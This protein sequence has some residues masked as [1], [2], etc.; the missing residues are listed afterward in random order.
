MRSENGEGLDNEQSDPAKGFTTPKTDQEDNQ[1]QGLLSFETVNPAGILKLP[2]KAVRKGSDFLFSSSTDQPAECSASED[3]NA[4]EPALSDKYLKTDPAFNPNDV[5]HGRLPEVP[6]VTPG[7][8]G[9]SNRIGN[10]AKRKVTAI[11]HPK[12]AAKQRFQSKTAAKLSKATR[13]YI[14]KESDREYLEA[15][16]ELFKAE[17]E[18]RHHKEEEKIRRRSEGS[19]ISVNQDERQRP[20]IDTTET[21]SVQGID[22]CGTQ[23]H[24]I[25]KLEAHRESLAVAWITGRHIK[26]VRLSPSYVVD[27][28][29]RDDE[30]FLERDETGNVVRFKWERYIGKVRICCSILFIELFLTIRPL[31]SALLFAAIYSETCRRH[32]G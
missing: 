28:P 30:Q 31:A 8:R 10:F 25:N 5:A 17:S 12:R 27:Y 26:R 2:Q 19:W 22:A 1:D 14:S 9:H 6:G 4:L 20:E 29:R 15:H 3:E 16:D 13:P 32:F 21:E 7:R 11:A 24:K 23:K 18:N